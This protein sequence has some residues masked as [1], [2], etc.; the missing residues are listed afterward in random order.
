ML[1]ENEKL[2]VLLVDDHILFAEGTVALLASEQKLEVMGIASDGNQC[3]SILNTETPDVILLDIGLPDRS[4]I[5]L[6]DEIRSKVPTVKVIMLTGL[7]PKGYI[8]IAMRKGVNGFLL[9]EC[10]KKEMIEAILDVAQGKEYFSKGLAHYLVS[11]LTDD[12]KDKTNDIKIN[13]KLLTSK[14]TEII[15][16]ITMG[17][18]SKEVANKLGITTRTV[19]FHMSNILSKLGARTRYEAIMIYTNIKQER[20][21]TKSL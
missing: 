17:L 15:E 16:L 19:D 8:T 12:E 13:D 18:R 14:E 5:D 1:P 2:K 4:G 10:N 6:I 11:E 20:D 21:V 9:K 3:L 7:N